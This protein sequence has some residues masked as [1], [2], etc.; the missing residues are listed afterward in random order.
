VSKKKRLAKA[1][2]AA[3]PESA[4]RD[5]SAYVYQDRKLKNPLNVNCRYSLTERQSL[6]VETAMDKS[7]K[8]IMIDGYWGTG[9]NLVATLAALKLMNE[10]KVSGIV[11]LRNPLE[12][13]NTAKV[14]TLPGSLEERMESYNAILFDKLNELLPKADIDLLRKEERIECIPVGLIQGKTFSCKAVILDEAASLSYDDLMLVVSRMGE[15]SKLFIIGD[16][17]FQLSIGAKSGFRRFFN[18]FN[19]NESMEHGIFTFELKQKDDI[20]RSGLLRFIMEKTGV[21]ARIEEGR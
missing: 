11:Y 3:T 6:I 20:R 12:A 4:P 10:K 15:Y 14:G 19:D 2:A 13:T 5:T 18:I 9:K 17:T 1:Q 16:S 21:I 7:S 8:V